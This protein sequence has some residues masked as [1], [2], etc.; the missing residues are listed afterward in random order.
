MRPSGKG[1]HREL[2]KEFFELPPKPQLLLIMGRLT[3]ADDVTPDSCRTPTLGFLRW[4]ATRYATIAAA[5]IEQAIAT[6]PADLR[7]GEALYQTGHKMRDIFD[8][9]PLPVP[10]RTQGG[11]EEWY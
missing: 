4:R 11:S 7:V 9:K 1:F 6:L 5:S 8:W 2:P 10:P 3:L